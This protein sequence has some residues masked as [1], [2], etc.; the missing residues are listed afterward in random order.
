MSVGVS[1][2]SPQKLQIQ[3]EILLIRKTNKDVPFVAS[4]CSIFF[5][6]ISTK[7]EGKMPNIQKQQYR[8]I[9]TKIETKKFGKEKVPRPNPDRDPGPGHAFWLL[10]SFPVGNFL[11]EMCVPFTS[12][13]RL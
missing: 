8:R 1:V 3:S 5:G 13:E 4:V 7:N 2:Y 6:L 11:M 9:T 12:F 10:P